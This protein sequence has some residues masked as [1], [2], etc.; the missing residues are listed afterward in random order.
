MGIDLANQALAGFDLS[1]KDLAYAN[2]SFVNFTNADLSSANL[3]N[4]NL[5][6]ADLNNADLSSANLTNA[7]L[8]YA[9]LSNADLS[10]AD[11]TGADLSYANLMVVTGFASPQP[12]IAAS[13]ITG[14]GLSGPDPGTANVSNANRTNA[15]PAGLGVILLPQPPAGGEAPNNE[16]QT[17]AE[18]KQAEDDQA[19][20]TGSHLSEPEITA[21]GTE[22]GSPPAPGSRRKVLSFKSVLERFREFRGKPSTQAYFSLFEQHEVIGFRQE[23]HVVLAD[24]V[25]RVRATIISVP[26]DR[27]A[28]DLVLMGGHLI[29][30]KRNAEFTNSW[31]VDMV[32]AKDGYAVSMTVPQDRYMMVYPLTVA[33]PVNIDLNGSGVVTEDDFALFLRDR[34]TQKQPKFDL[35]R[36]GK[37]DALDDYIFTA[38]YLVSRS[39]A[40]GPVGK[41]P[42]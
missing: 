33:P 25:K 34:G 3:T 30:M 10:N 15:V 28:S 26:G 14:T 23:P 22:S 13:N 17:T 41:K 29:S 19:K 5:S 4:A 21:E 39:A 27:N 11:L 40:R 8:S 38:N 36:D 20:Q 37:R 24:G 42:G 35:N 31:V 7:N 12:S 18:E 32:P 2:L 1:G 9:D 16:T 6:Y